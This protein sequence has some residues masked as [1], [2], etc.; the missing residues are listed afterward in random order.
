MQR[1][2]KKLGL[3]ESLDLEL[4]MSPEHVFRCLGTA[5]ESQSMSLTDLIT[6]N[7]NAIDYR[8]KYQEIKEKN[9]L[10]VHVDIYPRR[11]KLFIVTL[12]NVT[13]IPAILCFSIAVLGL[14]EKEYTMTF[15][16]LTVYALILL[17]FPIRLLKR[18]QWKVWDLRLDIEKELRR[19]E[20][21]IST[22]DN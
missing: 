21:Q 16:A 14:S 9:K 3:L 8:W 22:V 17:L 20:K 5:S 1:L 2:L 4:K 15:G 13:F 12:F 19:T 10:E 11:Y 6:V 18:M 7:A